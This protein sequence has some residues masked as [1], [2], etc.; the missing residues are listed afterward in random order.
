MVRMARDPLAPPPAFISYVETR[1]P[2]LIQGTRRYVPDERMADQLARDLLSAVAIRWPWYARG[3]PLMAKLFRRDPDPIAA[4]DRFL[5]RAFREGVKD[6]G[7]PQHVQ[8]LVLDPAAQLPEAPVPRTFLRGRLSVT[9]E[10]QLLWER[11]A[12]AVRRRSLII[13]GFALMGTL[14]FISRPRPE[15]QTTPVEPPPSPEPSVT[16]VP[17]GMDILPSVTE[18]SRLAVRPSPIP[19][20]LDLAKA[21]PVMPKGRRALAVISPTG[22]QQSVVV[23]DDGKLY[24]LPDDDVDIDNPA[25]LSPDGRY[26]AYRKADKVALYDIT[27]A[28]SRTLETSANLATP[29][30]LDA[31]R[32]M[33][34][35]TGGGQIVTVA[36]ALQGQIVPVD[37]ADTVVPQGYP[38]LSGDPVLRST[39]LLSIGRPL[40]A[41][42]RV[43]QHETSKDEGSEVIVQ[44]PLGAW[45]GLW[46]GIGFGVRTTIEPK[47]RGLLVRRCQTTGR[48]P[49]EYGDPQGAIIAIRA[50]DG[51]ILRVLLHTDAT[52]ADRVE[53]LGWLNRQTVM[54]TA[55][56]NEACVIVAWQVT[57]G[58]LDLFSIV[59]A[60]ARVALADLTVRAS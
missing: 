38:A 10:A 28:T 2:S 33:I 15:P 40:T 22:D 20:F 26:V 51:R 18:Q 52:D 53:P 35:V 36:G 17:S 25:A 43:R 60:P 39:E 13:G 59:S 42:A 32:L 8:P 56:S 12:Q 14:V 23:L 54:V 29:I 44:G 27:T 11:S 9:E 47:D 7:E 5:V 55:N 16:A 41:P 24:R 31:T 57:D 4:A 6:Y 49:A 19:A 30:W 37:I 1:L 46:R 34:S 21:N 3:V 45:L 50:T 48:L 58:R